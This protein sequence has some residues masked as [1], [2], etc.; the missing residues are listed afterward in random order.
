M[1]DG[2]RTNEG[3]IFGTILPYIGFST[4]AVGEDGWPLDPEEFESGV[5]FTE[6]RVFMFAWFGK[7]LMFPLKS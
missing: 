5:P 7:A 3:A 6:L 4:I 2:W 1:K